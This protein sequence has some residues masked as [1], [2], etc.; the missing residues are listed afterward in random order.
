MGLTTVQALKG[1]YN[2]KEVIVADRIDERLEMAKES[3]ADWVINNGQQSLQ[4]FLDEKGL[5]PTLIVDAAC[6]PS[7]LQEAISLASPPRALY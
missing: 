1:V 6:H 2:V 5:K 7:I 3:G 4:D